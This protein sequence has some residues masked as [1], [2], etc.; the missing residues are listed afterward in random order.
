MACF[1]PFRPWC[2]PGLRVFE[3]RTT[4]DQSTNPTQVLSCTCTPPQ[5]LGSTARRSALRGEADPASSAKLLAFI[6]GPSA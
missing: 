1:L 2:Y 5:W 4:R 6:H 3:V